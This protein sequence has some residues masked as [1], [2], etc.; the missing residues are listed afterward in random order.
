VAAMLQN[1]RPTSVVLMLVWGLTGS[2][3]AACPA[4]RIA[5]DAGHSQSRPGARSA[6]GLPEVEFN[7]AL[8]EV[9]AAQLR[10]QGYTVLPV[11]RR[12]E[13]PTL[14]ERTRRAAAFKAD[15]FLSLHHD[16][17]QPRY[18]LP[19]LTPDGHAEHYSDRFAGYSL[20]ISTVPARA[21]TAAASRALA[22]QL[23]SALRA[24]G[25]TPTLH[26]AEPIPGEG[27]KLLDAER[28]IYRFD[29][30][31]VLRS[32]TMPAVLLEAGVIVNRAEEARLRQP[33]YRQRIATAISTAL[34]AYCAG[35]Q[36]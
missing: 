30:L 12:D 27:R 21:E 5:L 28:G 25:L 33:A 17:V 16:S 2:V 13:Q 19:W 34:R 9:V 35:M 3:Q 1:R 29:E 10:T 11:N 4:L 6:S 8:A 20:F 36:P 14:T 23:G 32:A 24:A 22:M 18:L 7:V 31:V 26:H 15:L